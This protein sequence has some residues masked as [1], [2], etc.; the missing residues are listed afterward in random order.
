ML[1]F[2]RKLNSIQIYS[3]K[4][5]IKKFNV[6]HLSLLLT[7]FHK[8]SWL[9]RHLLSFL[10]ET[11]KS[12]SL[13]FFI[14][15]FLNLWKPLSDLIDPYRRCNF[16]KMRDIVLATQNHRNWTLESKSALF[17]SFWKVFSRIQNENNTEVDWGK[18]KKL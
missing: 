7:I 4:K 12:S 8:P 18:K 1:L 16:K 3:Q 13:I 11:F 14:F 2:F 17:F 15:L 6:L 10:L 9:L 5:K